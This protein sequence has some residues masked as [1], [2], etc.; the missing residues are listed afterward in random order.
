MITGA[1]KII[2]KTIAGVVVK[3]SDHNPKSQ[4]FLIFSDNTSYEFYSDETEIR[5]NTDIQPYGLEGVKAY[6]PETHRI[7]NEFY[8]E[9]LM[10]P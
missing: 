5:G 7:V 3:E 4:V 6:I 1:K 8:D 2:G 10:T 9:S